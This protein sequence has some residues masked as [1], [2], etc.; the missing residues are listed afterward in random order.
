MTGISSV[1]VHGSERVAEAT[2]SAGVA[3]ATKAR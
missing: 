3:E 1:L 2:N